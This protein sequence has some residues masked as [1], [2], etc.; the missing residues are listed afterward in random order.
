MAGRPR[1]YARWP[2]IRMSTGSRVTAA[3]IETATTTIAP[4]A[5]ERIVV[6]STRNRPASEIITVRPEKV[7]ARPE[8]RIAVRRAS[9]GR[10]PACISS[11]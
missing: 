4:R 10:A 1:V 8:V 6:E 11:R 3:R 2:M 9:S 7:T 5:I